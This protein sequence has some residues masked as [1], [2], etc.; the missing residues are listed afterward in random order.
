MK[1]ESLE[2]NETFAHETGDKTVSQLT[3]RVSIKLLF[4]QTCNIISVFDVMY[5]I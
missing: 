4:F 1:K 2:K 3:C 5:V